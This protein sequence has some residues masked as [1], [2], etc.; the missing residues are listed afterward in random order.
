MTFSFYATVLG[1]I[2]TVLTIFGAILGFCQSHLPSQMIK[3]LDGLLEQT[4]TF[5]ESATEDGVL[6]DSMLR[7]QILAKYVH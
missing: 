6:P 3:E 2:V 5:Y 4:Q 1:F 7:S